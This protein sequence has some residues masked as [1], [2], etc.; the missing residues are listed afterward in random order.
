MAKGCSWP[1]NCNAVLAKRAERMTTRAK[2]SAKSCRIE[3]LV[4]DDRELLKG[5]SE[6][7]APRGAGSGADRSRLA[8]GS[9]GRAHDVI[10]SGT[11]PSYYS[12]GLVTRI[13]KLELRVPRDGARAGSRP[14]C[15][16]GIQRSEKA[17]VSA[18]AEMYVQGV[19]THES[20]GRLTEE[21]C[22]HTFSASTVSRI[23][24]E[25]RCACCG[26]LPSAG[27]TRPIRT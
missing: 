23:R 20:Q 18:L 3:T 8:L 1:E 15:L 26:A 6:G 16:T 24:Q 14:S 17:L 2:R 25:P 19:S 10:A 5:L 13:G 21:L 9:P 12:R 11:G 7:I 27:S 22:G 4:G